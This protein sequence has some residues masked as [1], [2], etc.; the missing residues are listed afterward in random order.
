MYHLN[1]EPATWIQAIVGIVTIPVLF[2]AK[3][4]ANRQAIA[5]EKQAAASDAM[6]SVA[7]LQRIAAEESAT[8][9]RRQNEIAE[10]QA[11][12]NARP[13]LVLIRVFEEGHQHLY[14]ENQGAG[15]AHGVHW[16]IGTELKPTQ[17]QQ[18]SPELNL[19][20]SGY[21][22]RIN[23]SPDIP[24]K[25]GIV[26]ECYNAERTTFLNLVQPLKGEIHQQQLEIRNA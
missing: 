23:C 6:A 4:A 13:L 11:I 21:R 17:G 24:F 14:I 8:A 10:A 5:A 12:A 15:S 25:Q 9:A 7:E 19:L 22:T 18:K 2:A 16:W 20:G 3:T 26:I 1:F